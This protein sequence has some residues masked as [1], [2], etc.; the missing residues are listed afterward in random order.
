MPMRWT[1]PEF[2]SRNRQHSL[3]PDKAQG[4]ELD[5]EQDTEP[6]REPDKGEDKGEGKDEEKDDREREE[7]VDKGSGDSLELDAEEIRLQERDDVQGTLDEIR[8]Q[9]CLDGSLLQILDQDLGRGNQAG[10]RVLRRSLLF[11]PHK[12]R[13]CLQLPRDQEQELKDSSRAGRQSW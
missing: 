5:R 9:D 13:Q 7:A 3:E 8:P 2:R 4:M 10:P 1:S 11:H 12:H 6:G